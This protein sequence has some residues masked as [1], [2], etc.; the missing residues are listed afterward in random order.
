M[1]GARAESCGAGERPPQAAGGAGR[2]VGRPLR[3]GTGGR[4]GRFVS[5]PTAVP[6]SSGGGGGSRGNRRLGAG[7][8]AVWGVGVPQPG[9]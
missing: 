7:G 9:L 3:G 8:A 5:L 1:Q 2:A 6:A 4:A